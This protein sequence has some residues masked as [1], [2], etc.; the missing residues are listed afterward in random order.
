M[1]AFVPDLALRQINAIFE[2]FLS[3]D[4][5]PRLGTLV[6]SYRIIILQVLKTFTP[7][8]RRDFG[9]R[10]PGRPGRGHPSEQGRR[11]SAWHWLHQR[12]RWA[13]RRWRRR[14]RGV[15]PFQLDFCV[16]CLGTGV[17]SYR[18]RSILLWSDTRP[19]FCRALPAAAD[20]REDRLGGAGAC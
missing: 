3:P 12:P 8:S 19:F 14:R 2:S 5:D 16:R 18:C 7:K 10:C 1:G 11:I 15:G 9:G 13:L 20:H 4:R 6:S 17:A